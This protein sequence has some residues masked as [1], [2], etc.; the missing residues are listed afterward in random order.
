M[1]LNGGVESKVQHLKAR[2]RPTLMYSTEL[3]SEKWVPY[4]SRVAFLLARRARVKHLPTGAREEQRVLNGEALTCG[5]ILL[6]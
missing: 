2:V 4:P 6:V 5:R 1:V 3:N